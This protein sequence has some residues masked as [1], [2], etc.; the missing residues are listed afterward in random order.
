MSDTGDGENS[1]ASDAQHAA[2]RAKV[3]EYIDIGDRGREPCFVGREELFERVDRMVASSAVAPGD[4]TISIGG[5]P[6][7]GKSAFLREL[8]ERKGEDGAVLPVEIDAGECTA[9][10]VYEAIS[11]ALDLTPEP[12]SEQSRDQRGGIKLAG[13]GGE[14]GTA[15]RTRLASDRD[16]I[17]SRKHM[18]WRLMRERFLTP[19]AGRTVLLLCDEAQTLDDEDKQVQVAVRALQR[20]D[21][22]RAAP[23]RIVPVFAGLCDTEDKLQACGVWRETHGNVRSIHALS[24]KESEEYALKV[25]RHLDAEGSGGERAAWARWAVDN[26]DGWPHHLRG[27][28]EATAEA[29]ERADTPRLRPLD[30]AWIANRASENRREYY[31]KRV[32]G[33]GLAELADVF[34]A[35]AKEASR[36]GGA[37]IRDIVILANDMI[38]EELDPPKPRKVVTS[39]INAG[40]LQHVNATHVAC[41]IPSMLHWLETGHC[42]TPEPPSYS[43]PR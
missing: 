20:G 10:G 33:T 8:H 12:E 19:L 15:L 17:L 39:A 30:R 32:K 24:P 11:T 31:D 9:L 41:P 16:V 35:L 28:M 3:R 2:W 23:L 34:K 26:G 29:M 42:R 38:K 5:A 27:M 4:R 21:K 25:L 43:P 7:A 6:G 18:P 22:D 1:G 36:P 13:S 40:I 14:I 37:K